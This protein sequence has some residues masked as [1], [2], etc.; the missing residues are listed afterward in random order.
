MANT[1][2]PYSP[3]KVTAVWGGIVPIKGFEEGT[4]IEVARASENTRTKVGAQGDVGITINADKTGTVTL[5]LMQTS[6]S[7]RYLSA[8]QATQDATGDLIRESLQIKD[9]SGSM[10]CECLG[11]HIMTPPV[12]TLADDMSPKTWVFFSEKILYLEA[13][14]GVV[15][16]AA[17]IAKI[18]SIKATAKTASE[19]LL[20]L[21]I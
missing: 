4:F 3:E 12:I 2:R 20:E 18:N 13:P 7:N 17:T 1:L 6:E 16:S 14:I 8:L 5:T 15:N 11:V 9:E 19:A 21:T 10:L